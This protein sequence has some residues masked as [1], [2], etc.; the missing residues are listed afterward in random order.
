MMQPIHAS[1]QP[2]VPRIPSG[3][4]RAAA[5][6]SVASAVT[7][8]GLILLPQWIAQGSGFEARMVSKAQPYCERS[9]AR[10][11]GMHKIGPCPDDIG[12][13]SYARHA[14]LSAL[15]GV[16]AFGLWAVVEFCQQAMTRFAFDRWRTAWLA[17]DAT[18]R[19]TMAVR[20]AI[21][22]GLWDAA[23]VVILIAFLGGCMALATGLRRIGGLARVVSLG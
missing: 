16:G 4:Y 21:Y 1:L 22:D 20:A 12:R 2:V 7:T 5:V 3:F 15:L 18:V 17:G 6:A 11:E 8:L 23:Y 14:P 13:I 9:D 10:K 19:E